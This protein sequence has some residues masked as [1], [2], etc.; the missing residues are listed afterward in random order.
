[1]KYLPIILLSILNWFVANIWIV[2]AVNTQS[3]SLSSSS[4]SS[5]SSS[6]SSKCS[7]SVLEA[8]DHDMAKLMTIGQR[9]WPES[10]Q[11]S[12]KFC[13]ESRRLHDKINQYKNRCSIGTAKQFTSVI[14]YSIQRAHKTYCPKQANKKVIN[15]F[16]AQSCTNRVMNQTTKCLN[17]Y[18]DQLQ[19]I[20]RAPIVKQIPHVCCQYFEMLKCFDKEY[21]KIPNCSESAEI[22]N[23]FVRQIFDDIVN[24]S[25]QDYNESTDRCEHLGQPPSLLLTKKKHFKSFI[26]PLIDIWNQVDGQ[27]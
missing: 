12:K 27:K 8:Y 9:I 19:A 10:Y 6:L 23:N 13:I 3:S 4:N 21:E 7:S 5:S 24:L 11:D 17:H 25:C 2:A 14:I 26:L 15:F 22:F 18:I 1:M 20:I 16:K